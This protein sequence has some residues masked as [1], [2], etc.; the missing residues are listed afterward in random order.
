MAVCLS[1]KCISDCLT[2][3]DC[4]SIVYITISSPEDCQLPTILTG[5]LS[6][7]GIHGFISA[8]FLP[9]CLFAMWIP[10]Y[11]FYSC[12]SLPG[13]LFVRLYLTVCLSAAS[14]LLSVCLCC[15][16]TG[17]IAVCQEVIP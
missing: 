8:S 13:R 5:L 3:S 11:T 17:Y 2:T 9:Y 7:N 14:Q 12:Q 4:L 10:Y 15:Y 16:L 1:A 6:V